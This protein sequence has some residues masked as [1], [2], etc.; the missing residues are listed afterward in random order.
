MSCPNCS[1][2]SFIKVKRGAAKVFHGFTTAFDYCEN[3]KEIDPGSVEIYLTNRREALK[4]IAESVTEF[5]YSTRKLKNFC[6]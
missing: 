6:H 3:C 1:N 5:G 4:E 2:G